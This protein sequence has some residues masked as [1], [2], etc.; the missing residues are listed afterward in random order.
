MKRFLSTIACAWMAFSALQ[1]V[2][3]KRL[4]ITHVQKDGTTLIVTKQGD[5]HLHYYVL[6]FL[7]Y[8]N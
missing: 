5:E 2:P 3:A 6:Y 8:L 4:R 7:H 1:A